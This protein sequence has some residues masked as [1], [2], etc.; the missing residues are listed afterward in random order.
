MKVNKLFNKTAVILSVTA[1]GAGTI[2]PTISAKVQAQDVGNLVNDGSSGEQTKKATTGD[3]Y[4]SSSQEISETKS[5]YTLPKQSYRNVGMPVGTSQDR[6]PL[7]Y[8]MQP[9]AELTIQNNSDTPI[10]VTLWTNDAAAQP[11]P[12]TIKAHSSATIK[13]PNPPIQHTDAKGN[14]VGAPNDVDLVPFINTPQGNQLPENISVNFTLSGP[15]KKLPVFDY[16]H[17]DQEEFLKNWSEGDSYAIVAGKGFQILLPTD[18]RE[19]VENMDKCPMGVDKQGRPI[20]VG[21]DQYVC[22]NLNDVLHFYDDILYPVY[23]KIVGLTT[24]ASEPYNKLINYKY[25]Y[26]ADSHGAGGANYSSARAETSTYRDWT[27]LQPTWTVF[28][29][30]GHGYQSTSMRLPQDHDG[31]VTNNILAGYV[32]YHYLYK[33]HPELADKYSWF[34]NGDKQKLETKMNQVLNDPA[35]NWQW[36]TILPDNKNLGGF[37]KHIGLILMYNMVEKMGIDGWTDVYKADRAQY[38]NG[39]PADPQNL[40]D[41]VLQAAIKSGYDFSAAFNEIGWIPSDHTAQNSQNAR[42]QKGKDANFLWYLMP[43]SSYD[44]VYDVVKKLVAADSNLV[45]QSNYTMVTPDQMEKLGLTGS[46]TLQFNDLPNDWVGKA[47]TLM[48][49][50]QVQG[51]FTIGPD[52]KAQI[53]DVPIGTYTIGLP[54]DNHTLTNYYVTVKYKDPNFVNTTDVKPKDSSSSSS[55]ASS[56]SSKSSS[57]SSIA[58]SSSS[59][60]SSSSSVASSSSSKSSSSSLIASSSSSKSSSSSSVASS[61]SSKSS[62]SS[63][64]ASSSSSKSSSSSSVASSSSSKSSSSS[65]IVSSSSSKS[66]SSS[67]IVSSSSS[68]TEI[69]SSSIANISSESSSTGN[70]PSTS[71]S[72]VDMPSESGSTGEVPSTSSSIVGIPSESSSTGNVPATSSSSSTTGLLSGPSSNGGVPP[73]TSS[74]SNGVSKPSQEP[75]NGPSEPAGTGIPSSSSNVFVSSAASTSSMSSKANS[76]SKTMTNDIMEKSSEKAK[77]SQEQL[78][79][80]GQ[81]NSGLLTILGAGLLALLGFMKRFT[82]KDK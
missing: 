67:S 40:E 39:K 21:D 61:S 1:V 62:S 44:E 71:S 46:T 12:V 2:A 14:P 49:G 77:E 82:R 58:S 8:I 72:T 27:W 42:D 57:S 52:G 26:T 66:S 3:S 37:A 29:E 36:N 50:D 33:G 45:F 38:Y 81:T 60:S 76:S 5:I 10:V 24:D 34:F 51:Q 13:A 79:E 59:K 9:G 25:F 43:N 31:E 28:H 80:T 16:E 41:L 74:S 47:I 4:K 48:N 20:A 56:S 30:T 35:Y 15:H 22:H 23:N 65:S 6:Q 68:S 63:S 73:V 19:Y 78:P 54:D 32:F 53:T 75:S 18:D 7:G 55:I 69:V 70:M 17:N 64:V 11:R